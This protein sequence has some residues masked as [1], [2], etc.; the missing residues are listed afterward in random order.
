MTYQAHVN[1]MAGAETDVIVVGSGAG[2]MTAALA[3]AHLGS[4][5]VILEKAEQI[6][7]TTA[8]SAGAAW[9]P[10]S[11]HHPTEDD[12]GAART[13]LTHSV[14]NRMNPAIIGAMLEY[15][16]QVVDF[17][18]RQTA[19]RFRVFGAMDYRSSVPGAATFS[20]T[21]EPTA[22]DDRE[23]GEAYTLL[24]QPL[25]ALTLL[26]GMQ[27]DKQDLA[28][29]QNV[30]RSPRSLLAATALLSRH[31][32]DLVRFGR[33]TRRLRGNALAG[34]L[35]KSILDTGIGVR[36]GARCHRLILSGGR[37]EGVEYQTNA[38]SMT[39]RTRQ[40]VVL[41]SG[42][43]SADAAAR[44]D[45]APYPKHHLSLP[46]PTNIGDGLAMAVQAGARLSDDNLADYCFAPVSTMQVPS[47]REVRY[48]HFVRDRCLPGC[49]AINVA[50]RRFVNEG[51]SYHD[52]VLAMHASGSVP[53]FLLCDHR[54]LRRYGLGLVRPSPFPVTMFIR[55]GYLMRAPTIRA[56]A[57]QM[58][59]DPNGTER[60]VA[61]AN[62]YA[63]SGHDAEFAKG[64]D[65]F[66]RSNGDPRCQPN[67]CLGPISDGP[68]YAIRVYPGDTGTIRGLVTNASAQVLDQASL[69]IPGLYACGM[70]MNNPTMGS[71]PSGGL[72]LGPAIVFGYLAGSHAAG[73][74]G[75]RAN[76]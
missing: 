40:G 56:L 50:G 68:F 54:F 55:Q 6:G 2:G 15:A 44:N 46:P 57:G 60:S 65:A 5:V 31:Y 53:A 18:E 24:R 48:P 58:G 41:A 27:T 23:L 73:Q 69:P 39:L 13:Y 64:D 59:T 20:R 45:R 37:V 52:F 19:V 26:H 47:G 10:G 62:Q 35:F 66:S 22:F 61:L 1:L 74:P 43:F 34:M 33:S 63:A 14:G 4:D 28:H 70:D 17:L 25:Q 38:G 51:C 71:H 67:P 36:T 30:F 72:N 11:N 49:I 42:G 3:A 32:L 21:L 12:A 7:G 8:W 75:K 76:P 29:L 9:L 16:P